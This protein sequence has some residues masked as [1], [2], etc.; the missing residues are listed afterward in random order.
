MP[1]ALVIST[2]DAEL[3]GRVLLMPFRYFFVEW[4]TAGGG[5]P[6]GSFH[7][8]SAPVS[9]LAWGTPAAGFEI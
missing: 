9:G 4:A 3:L 7:F 8:R 2:G 1:I 6:G 5:A